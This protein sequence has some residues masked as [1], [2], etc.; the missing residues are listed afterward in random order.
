[1]PADLDDLFLTLRRHADAIPG[2]GSADARRLGTRRRNR[3]RA[4]TTAALAVCLAAGTAVYLLA[5]PRSAVSPALSYG[6]EAREATS[7]IEGDV[8]FTAWVA[9]DGEAGVQAATLSTGASRWR[10][11]MPAHIENLRGVIALPH[12][13]LMIADGTATVL[14]PPTGRQLWTFPYQV[15]DDLIYYDD[16]LVRQEKE[17]GATRAYDWATGDV[18][19]EQ[20]ATADPPQRTLGMFVPSDAERVGRFGIPLTFK[21]P[22]LVQVTRSG[23]VRIRDARTG[24]LT[25]TRGAAAMDDLPPVAFDGR[26]YSV[27]RSPRFAVRVTEL[28]GPSG[29]R[30]VHTGADISAIAPCGDDRVCVADRSGLTAITIGDGRQ[31]WRVPAPEGAGSIQFLGD[32][33]VV[34]GAG[35]QALYGT[36]GRRLAAGRLGRLDGRHVLIL[37]NAVGEEIVRVTPATGAQENAGPMPDA[38]FGCTWATDKLA[39][40]GPSALEITTLKD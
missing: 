9:K 20:P 13:V 12:A 5:P 6:T 25:Q 7:A 31:A 26:L 22:R 17:T 18:R 28:T 15:S 34:D 38:G 4:L 21:D 35:E 11:G 32:G 30:V 33:L 10:V 29:S 23:A 14:D 27:D 24:T 37:P 40:P 1:M 39:C 8:V 36:D 3:M 19:W 16:L 2:G